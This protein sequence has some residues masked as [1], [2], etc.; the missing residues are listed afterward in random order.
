M[1][2]LTPVTVAL[3]AL[4]VVI[5]LYLLTCHHTTYPGADSSD[6]LRVQCLSQSLT[7]SIVRLGVGASP[8]P[9]LHLHNSVSRPT[10]KAN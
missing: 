5:V 9:V 7:M 2:P 10:F 3:A 8:P 6:F 4:F 1:R